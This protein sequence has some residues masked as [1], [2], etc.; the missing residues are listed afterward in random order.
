[1]D[2]SVL[3]GVDLL[4]PV[5]PAELDV[6]DG[7]V[8]A[9]AAVRV[10]EVVRAVVDVAAGVRRLALVL[11]RRAQLP[12]HVGRVAPFARDVVHR[13]HVVE[14]EGHLGVAVRDGLSEL[15][16]VVEAADALVHALRDPA[17][18]VRVP[19]RD[20]F[21]NGP[22][23]RVALGRR[24]RAIARRRAA[25]EDAG[26]RPPALGVQ[27]ALPP[28]PPRPAPPPPRP[29]PPL[30]RGRAAPPSVAGPARLPRTP[31]PLP[32]PPPPGAAPARRRPCSCTPTR[33]PPTSRSTTITVARR[34][35]PLWPSDDRLRTGGADGGAGGRGRAVRSAKGARAR[36]PAARDLPRAESRV[37]PTSRG[38]HCTRGS[39]KCETRAIRPCP[40]V[41]AP[42]R[43]GV[44]QKRPR[45]V[46]G[47]L[48]DG[49]EKWRPSASR[50][51]PGRAGRGRG[52]SRSR[53]RGTPRRRRP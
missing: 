9:R 29:A 3:G 37:E 31:P 35:I 47:E 32:P 48:G 24:P 36:E 15:R 20:Q 49:A 28:P 17:P 51:R 40:P 11:G 52:P 39:K 23:G 25:R 22:L 1:M 6:L 10:H 19:V 2:G 21:P 45:S 14:L 44:A 16:R 18:A 33:N 5:V 4:E 38:A 53:R 43:A 27:G 50:P 12:P 26:D 30:R 7:G 34:I 8:L 13:G 41:L 42:R 46:G